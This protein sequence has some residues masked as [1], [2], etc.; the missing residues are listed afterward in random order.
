[1]TIKTRLEE[2]INILNSYCKK[3][4]DNDVD[5]QLGASLASIKGLLR[6]AKRITERSEQEFENY[7]IEDNEN[8][9]VTK[10]E[11][12]LIHGVLFALVNNN[13]EVVT[14]DNGP[15][16]DFRFNQTINKVVLLESIDGDMF[17]RAVTSKLDA[18]KENEA[19]QQTDKYHLINR[20]RAD[21][22]LS[23]LKESYGNNLFVRLSGKCVYSTGNNCLYIVKNGLNDNSRLLTPNGRKFFIKNYEDIFSDII[24][25]ENIGALDSLIHGNGIIELSSLNQL[26]DNDIDNYSFVVLDKFLKNA[27][28]FPISVEEEINFSIDRFKNAFNDCNNQLLKSQ[29]ELKA[30]T[31][32]N[33]NNTKLA[34]D[35]IRFLTRQKERGIIYDFS[36]LDKHDLK[37]DHIRVS[38]RNKLNEFY[39]FNNAICEIRVHMNWAPTIYIDKSILYCACND[40]SHSTGEAYKRYVVPKTTENP[41][42]LENGLPYLEP[43]T[44]LF[45]IDNSGNISFRFAGEN[46]PGNRLDSYGKELYEQLM[47]GHA[48]YGCLGTFSERLSKLASDNDY[49]RYISSVIQYYQTLAPGDVAGNYSLIRCPIVEIATGKVL[50]VPH[51]TLSLIASEEIPN[52]DKHYVKGELYINKNY[53]NDLLSGKGNNLFTIIEN[54]SKEESSST[55]A[56]MPAAETVAAAE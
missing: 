10:A 12:I 16:Y 47:H 45:A 13:V 9:E 28:S 15:T 24:T 51:D 3:L 34:D 27:T 29:A 53:Y 52:A 11:L 35:I 21:N 14:W 44:I 8:A 22:P 55:T 20:F 49:V 5:S 7:D 54:S 6:N 25:T 41:D 40:F 46:M 1:M 38:D 50:Y 39:R 31:Q 2:Y 23:K 43:I 56:T 48:Y 32:F 17:D 18:D 36:I 42:G 33:G 26:T 4:E 30:L 37:E 19:L